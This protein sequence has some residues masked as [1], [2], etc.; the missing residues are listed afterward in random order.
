MTDS[1]GRR[2]EQQARQRFHELASRI[3]P[4][5]GRISPDIGRMTCGGQEIEQQRRTVA[6]VERAFELERARY[7]TGIDPYINL[8]QEQTLLLG[9]RQAL[10]S[11]Q[12]QQMTSAVALVETFGGGWDRSDLPTPGQVAKPPP[13]GAREI[14]Q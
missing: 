11:L 5:G 10:V 1:A 12:V 2:D 6:L 8:M 7:E 14:R 9:V 13:A 4:R 3:A